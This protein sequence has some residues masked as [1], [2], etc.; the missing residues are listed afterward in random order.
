M[1]IFIMIVLFALSLKLLDKLFKLT[2]KDGKRKMYGFALAFTIAIEI[3][4]AL[5]KQIVSML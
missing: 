1:Y 4:D 3:C 5:S 2:D